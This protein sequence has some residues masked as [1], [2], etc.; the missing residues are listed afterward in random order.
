MIAKFGFTSKK[1]NSTSRKFTEIFE[2]DVVLKSDTSIVTPVFKV[3]GG[4]FPVYNDDGEIVGWNEIEPINFD[5][6][7]NCNYVLYNGAYY[8]I[9]DIISDTNWVSEFVCSRDVLATFLPNIRKTSAYVKYGPYEWYDK[10]GYLDDKRFSPDIEG[11]SFSTNL[12]TDLFNF[13]N[14]AS[15]YTVIW[16]V[17]SLGFAEGENFDYGTVTLCCSFETYINCCL[18]WSKAYGSDGNNPDLT[19]VGQFLYKMTSGTFAENVYS[20]KLYPIS[21]TT[22]TTKYANKFKDFKGTVGP[23]SI[24][25]ENPNIKKV[26]T[27]IP[28]MSNKNSSGLEAKFRL[29]VANS[30]IP[31]SEYAFL[32]GEKY[33]DILLMTPNG[34]KNIASNKFINSDTSYDIAYEYYFDLYTGNTT[35]ALKKYGSNIGEI[36][37]VVSWNCGVDVITYASSGEGEGKVLKSNIGA[38]A[39]GVGAASVAAGALTAIAAG[40][41]GAAG[42]GALLASRALPATEKTLVAGTKLDLGGRALLNQAGAGINS[43]GVSTSQALTIGTGISAVISDGGNRSQS[44]NQN[45]AEGVTGLWLN[46]FDWNYSKLGPIARISTNTYLPSIFRN[47]SKDANRDDYKKF[48]EAYGYPVMA[49]KDFSKV[50]GY[51]ECANFDILCGVDEN[52]SLKGT[53]ITLQEASSINSLLNSGVYIE[54]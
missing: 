16:T 14:D 5:K 35:L 8:W 42:G 29:P 7:K 2:A 24:M 21:Y 6:V 47:W 23:Y 53:A 34:V 36:Y 37:E 3:V 46:S 32:R 41:T 50:K 13:N 20:A 43:V 51:V 31:S 30:T 40:I 48:C 26:V 4:R 28:I 25:S 54:D 38:M 52:A 10:N 33:T 49:Y 9:N 15:D 11:K 18:S 27:I 1:I 12:S 22:L 17:N 19:E 44:Q 39:T 45:Y